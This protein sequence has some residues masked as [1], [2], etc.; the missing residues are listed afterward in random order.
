VLLV[1]LAIGAQR[2]SERFSLETGDGGANPRLAA[3][4]VFYALM[5]SSAGRPTFW[6]LVT[7]ALIGLVVLARRR[8]AF[9]ALAVGLLAVPPAVY[10]FISIRGDGLS[11]VSPRHLLFLLPLWTVLIALGVERLGRRLPTVAEALALAALAIATALTPIDGV[12]DVRT[13]DPGNAANGERSTLE[14]PAAALAGTIAPNDVLYPH[15]QAFLA[16]LPATKRGYVVMLGAG[17]LVR[18]GF[19]RVRFPVEAVVVPVPIGPARVDE[20][21]LARAPGSAI[22]FNRW[23]VVRLTGP[24]EDEAEALHAIAAAQAGVAGA[25]RGTTPGFAGYMR[26]RQGAICGRLRKL[27]PRERCVPVRGVIVTV[28]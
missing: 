3:R 28:P 21:R 12:F 27:L 24:F 2:L 15:S 13:R 4:Q 14:G 5:G 26:S 9:A 10:L 1:P 20:S 23:V 25:A 6:L 16:A 11:G 7:L 8:L 22:A 19:E 18:L 17:G